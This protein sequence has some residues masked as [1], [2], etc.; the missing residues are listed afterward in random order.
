MSGGRITNYTKSSHQAILKYFGYLRNPKRLS[1][2]RPAPAPRVPHAP[3]VPPALPSPL[4]LHSPP[5][6]PPL[7][8]PLALHSSHA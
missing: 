2:I 3:R 8:A 4:A 5:A 1:Y 6:P 7:P